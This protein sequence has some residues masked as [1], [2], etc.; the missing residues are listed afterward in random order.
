[1]SSIVVAGD[2]SGTCTLQAPAVAG[3]TVLTLP[4][5]SGTVLTS[6]TGQTLTSPVINGMGSSILTSGTAQASTSGTAIDFTGIPSWAKRITVMFNGVSTNGASFPQVQIGTSG[7]IQTSGY[8][9]TSTGIGNASGVSAN[10]SAGFVLSAS[11]SW[12]AASSLNGKI[13]LVLLDAS[14]GIWACSGVVG[15]T[16]GTICILI[17]GVKTLS[18]TLDRIRLTTVNG[19]DTFDAGSINIMYE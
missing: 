8:T 12:T 14:T 5:V 1:M 10:L 4:A 11:G 19:T 9:G 16:G 17:G 13:D 6:A 2:T 18:G 15:Y 3:S 7:G